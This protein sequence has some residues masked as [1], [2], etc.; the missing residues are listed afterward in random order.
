MTNERKYS[1]LVKSHEHYKLEIVPSPFTVSKVTHTFL[2]SLIFINFEKSDDKI[3]WIECKAAKWSGALATSWARYVRETARST[4]H[5]D[6]Y[7]SVGYIKTPNMNFVFLLQSMLYDVKIG[8][9]QTKT[10]IYDENLH[11]LSFF[12]TCFTNLTPPFM[13]TLQ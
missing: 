5:T 6:T 8:P 12:E 4:K 11:K 7:V 10:V 3:V 2:M 1:N 13:V 9:H